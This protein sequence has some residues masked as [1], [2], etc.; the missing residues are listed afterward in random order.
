ES[1]VTDPSLDLTSGGALRITAGR[2]TDEVDERSWIRHDSGAPIAGVAWAGPLLVGERPLAGGRHLVWAVWDL[3]QGSVSARF[4][5]TRRTV[6][7]L[8]CP[9]AAVYHLNG[10]QVPVQRLEGVSVFPVPSAG[11]WNVTAD[12]PL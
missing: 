11:T 12:A 9:D 3:A 5:T 2:W 1:G 10:V 4:E 8:S 7:H 6:V